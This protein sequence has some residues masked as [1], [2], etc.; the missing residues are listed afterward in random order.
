MTGPEERVLLVGLHRRDSIAGHALQC[1]LLVGIGTEEDVRA[2]RRE[3][4]HLDNVMFT[5]GAR[6]EIP[7][8]DHYFT[9]ILDAGGG[10]PTAAMQRVLA[11][12]GRI[13]PV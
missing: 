8:R 11:P 6:D 9:V 5:P 13:I 1:G 3:F 10:E 2:A 12:G 4:A 7:W